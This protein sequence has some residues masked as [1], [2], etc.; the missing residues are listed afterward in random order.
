MKKKTGNSDTRSG[1]RH[2]TDG[3]ELLNQDMIRMLGEKETYK[4]LGVFEADTIK[5]VQMKDKI[6]K[7]IP[8]EN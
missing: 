4:Y 3:M 6:K 8:L 2:L 1:K 7:R 5:Q